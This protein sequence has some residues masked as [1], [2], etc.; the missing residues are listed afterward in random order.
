MTITV[1]AGSYQETAAFARQ[2]GLGYG[3]R[4]V[5]NAKTLS[6]ARPREIHVLPSFY[7]RRDFHAVNMMLKRI[8]RKW[9]GVKRIEYE[10]TAAGTY[11]VASPGGFPLEVPVEPAPAAPDATPAPVDPKEE[12]VNALSQP[13]ISKDAVPGQIPIAE[14]LADVPEAPAAA[15][16]F[17]S[18]P[19]DDALSFL[20]D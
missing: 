12:R 6:G 17:R 1:L 2:M 8:E 7:R 3:I 16:N 9:S 15:Q 5:V 18:D 4:H 11:V 10:M 13:D 14:A 19:D 20:D